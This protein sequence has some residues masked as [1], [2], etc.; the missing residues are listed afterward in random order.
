VCED[1][2]S[3]PICAILCYLNYEFLCYI[4]ECMMWSHNLRID[5]INNCELVELVVHLSC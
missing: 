2:G 4:L 1:L 5:G 3:S